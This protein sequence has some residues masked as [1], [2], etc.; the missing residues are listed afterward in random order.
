[1]RIRESYLSNLSRY[2]KTGG[3]PVDVVEAWLN[4]H[5]EKRVE[6]KEN[7]GIIKATKA[8][9]FVDNLAGKLSPAER[10][11]REMQAQAD[12]RKALKKLNKQA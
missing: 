12:Y 5:P 6:N 11:Q 10:K 7:G 1:M 4:E 9:P 2:Q 8:A 3:T